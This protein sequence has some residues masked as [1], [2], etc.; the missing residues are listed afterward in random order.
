MSLV[1]WKGPTNALVL[2]PDSPRLVYGDRV[3]AI[4]I[5]KGMQSLCAASMVP[6]GTFG[7]GLRS[8]WVCNQCTCDTSRGDIGT[9]TIEW[10][11]GGS[12]ADQPLPTGDFTLQPQEIYP[13][14]ERNP[15]FGDVNG[16]ANSGILADTI[17]GVYNGLYK[18]Q[19][20]GTNASTEI[21]Q[22]VLGVTINSNGANVQ[23]G[24]I[25]FAQY[26]NTNAGAQIQL[27]QLLLDK[28][29][30]GEESYY[31]A[32][33]RYSF[34]SYS[35]TEP[36]LSTGGIIANASNGTP[37]GPI[38]PNGLPAGISWLRLADEVSPAGV[39]GSMY[40]LTENWIGGSRGYWDSD[41]YING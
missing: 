32:G 41:L 15:F 36:I 24:G 4:D 6:R 22:A 20:L 29:A 28:L 14:I 9:L 19:T 26:P 33:Y 39:N 8:G 1:I 37:G 27:G 7:S 12:D 21:T 35:Y 17:R 40:K 31:I 3:K 10:E 25:N 11:A 30:N 5:Y 16:Q 34:V 13:K 23:V 2:Q 38:G 18:G